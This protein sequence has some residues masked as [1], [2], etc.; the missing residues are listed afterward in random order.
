MDSQRP[1]VSALCLQG[2]DSEQESI[3]RVV[4]ALLGSRLLG[5]DFSTCPL[6]R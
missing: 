1:V 2:L 5:R 3:P 4:D 6:V